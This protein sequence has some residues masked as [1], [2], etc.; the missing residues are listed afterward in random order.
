MSY[1]SCCNLIEKCHINKFVFSISYDAILLH[2][3]C[4]FSNISNNLILSKLQFKTSRTWAINAIIAHS[5]PKLQD[6]IT[7]HTDSKANKQKCQQQTK[8]YRLCMF[9]IRWHLWLRLFHTQCLCCLWVLI[10][11]C[12]CKYTNLHVSM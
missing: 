7:T 11:C 1:A 12:A 8:Q 2:K 10:Y 3:P 6:S 5:K 4:V 9:H